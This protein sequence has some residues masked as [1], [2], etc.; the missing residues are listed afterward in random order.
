MADPVDDVSRRN[1]CEYFS[2][3]RVPFAAPADE[4]RRAD[5]R[6]RLEALFKKPPPGE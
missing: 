4:K 5:A 6:A 1:F 2:F 3:S